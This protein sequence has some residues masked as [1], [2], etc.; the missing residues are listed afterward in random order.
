MDQAALTTLALL[1]D[2]QHL[3]ALTAIDPADLATGHPLDYPAHMALR[4]I[5][6]HQGPDAT[7]DFLTRPT[8]VRAC[9]TPR[10]SG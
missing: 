1:A 2:A 3:A 7:E 8:S 9:S 6:Q 10:S 4:E 5:H